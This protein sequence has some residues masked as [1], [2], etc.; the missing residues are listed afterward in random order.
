ML[1]NKEDFKIVLIEIRTHVTIYKFTLGVDYITAVLREHNYNV[2][3]I[4]FESD[5]VEAMKERIL[6]ENPSLLGI[7]FY[8]ETEDVVFSLTRQLKKENPNMKICIGGSTATLYGTQIL[9]KEAS[10]DF[11][12]KGEGEYTHLEVC[13]LLSNNQDLKD[14]KGVIYRDGDMIMSNEMR[15]FIEDLDELPLPALD[16]IIEKAAQDNYVFAGISTS[17]GCFGKCSFCVANRFYDHKKKMGWR[18]RSPKSIV[19]E[20]KRLKDTF[21]DKR[22]FFTIVDSSI[23]DPYPDTKERLFELVTLLEENNLRIPFNCFTRAESWSEKDAELIQRLKKVGLFEVSIGYESSNERT[24]ELFNKRADV[25]D[26]YRAYKMFYDAGVNVFGFLIMFHPYATIEELKT[27]ADLL[28]KVRMGYH[29]QSWFQTLDLWPDS[30][31]FL[32]LAQDGLLLGPEPQGYIFNYA[33]EDGKIGRI[34]KAM[35]DIANSP[36]S[37]AYSDTNEKIK[38]ECLLYNAWRPTESD[39]ELIDEEMISYQKMYEENKD[40][41]SGKQYDLFMKLIHYAETDADDKVIEELAEEWKE[42]LKENQ[43]SLERMWLQLSMKMSRKKVCIIGKSSK[44]K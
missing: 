23:E 34:N 31:M 18:G 22:I 6:A 35:L 16:G 41:M 40:Y 21:P 24:L 2:C 8:R 14:C 27:N 44:K 19:K 36:S 10:I 12:V 30:R 29:P 39:L 1:V 3:N 42:L 26:N 7:S 37:R 13:D 11:V 43:I 4:T 25:D 5:D 28:V 17:R 33:F 32:G 9:K 15:P 20:I 38:L